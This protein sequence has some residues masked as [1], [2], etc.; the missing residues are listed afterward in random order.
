MR[1]RH[2]LLAVAAV[3]LLP[4]TAC[5]PTDPAVE[6][7]SETEDGD[8]ANAPTISD[9]GR[10]VAFVSDASNIGFGGANGVADVF[11]HDRATD[12]T[13]PVTTFGNGPSGWAPSCSGFEGG[14]GCSDSPFQPEA[15]A[16]SPATPTG[17]PT[18]S[19]TTSTPARPPA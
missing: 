3:A 15:P 10:F 19:P 8:A 11:V 9:S 6:R 4:L 1:A 13:R 7:V 12:D 17:P 2:G 14:V 16:I 5:E 18:C